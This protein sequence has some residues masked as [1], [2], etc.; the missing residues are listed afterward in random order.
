MHLLDV[1][2]KIEELDVG[3]KLSQDHDRNLTFSDYSFCIIIYHIYCVFMAEFD[4]LKQKPY[5]KYFD[6]RYMNK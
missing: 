1:N 2:K 3:T 5:H 6:L 4:S